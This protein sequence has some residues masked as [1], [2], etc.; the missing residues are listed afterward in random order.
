MVALLSLFIQ[1]SRWFPFL[2]KPNKNAINRQIP[3]NLRTKT[4]YCTSGLIGYD[5]CRKLQFNFVGAFIFDYMCGCIAHP[6]NSCSDVHSSLGLHLPQFWW[7]PLTSFSSDLK[8]LLCLVGTGQQQEM[9]RV[10]T[11]CLLKHIWLGP[12][13]AMTQGCFCSDVPTCWATR[14][15]WLHKSFT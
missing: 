4:Q 14:F 15:S 5:R 13:Q 3:W 10:Q 8:S 6:I 9:G 11:P 12:L 2:C 7:N 1:A